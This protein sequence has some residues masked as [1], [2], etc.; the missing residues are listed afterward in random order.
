M[1]RAWWSAR[2]PTLLLAGVVLTTGCSGEAGRGDAAPT[3]P[4]TASTSSSTTGPATSPATRPVNPPPGNAGIV[5]VSSVAELEAALAAAQPG[6]VIELAAGTYERDGGDRWQ[7]TADGSK[8]KPIT[9]SGPRSA[10]LTSDSI[11]GDY[12][13]HV[14]GDYW[15]IEGLSVADATKGIV[16]D[17]S[18]GTLI[19]EVDV[20]NVGEEGVHF[21]SCSS[22]GVLQK[23]TIHDTGLKK[24]QFGEGVYV[25]SANSNWG[26]YGCEG[27]QDKSQR[28][29]IEDNTFTHIAAEGADL[30]EG[31]DS[32]TL[33][34]NTFVDAGYSGENSADS[35]IDVKANGW[36]IEN[37][38]V[39]DPTGAALDAIQTHSV[40]EGYGTGNT[41]RGNRVQGG[42]PGFGIGLYPKLGNVVGCS[43]AAPDAKLG[44]VGDA[45]KPADCS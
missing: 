20:G 16:L 21:R 4:V 24:P 30:K 1:R 36:L 39:R 9:L 45:G 37:N 5:R 41:V 14:T 18:V 23:S 22:D 43:N 34:G 33:R 38:V 11:T 17:G 6:T 27:G 8:A 26:K 15:R 3:P 25:G 40:F 29:R 13:L 12:G 32:G 42:W 35:A 31:V 2:V 19:S 7:A 44:L 10:V 28:V